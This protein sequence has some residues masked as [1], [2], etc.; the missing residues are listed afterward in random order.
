MHCF[1]YKHSVYFLSFVSYRKFLCSFTLKTSQEVT[2]EI[3]KKNIRKKVQNPT[4]FV[5]YGVEI[6][7][8]GFQPS[9]EFN[10][11]VVNSICEIRMRECLPQKYHNYDTCKCQSR[12]T[13]GSNHKFGILFTN[14]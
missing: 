13:I 8:Q 9:E 7:K 12:N 4:L 14:S 5:K 11:T 2:P 3:N 1:F 6:P 10:D